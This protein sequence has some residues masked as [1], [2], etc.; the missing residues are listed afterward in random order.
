MSLIKVKL[1][2]FLAL[3]FLVKVC[4]WLYVHMQMCVGPGVYL[5]QCVKLFGFFLA[6]HI[7]IMV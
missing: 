5:C 6:L 2:N 7:I 4:K 1:L 3:H